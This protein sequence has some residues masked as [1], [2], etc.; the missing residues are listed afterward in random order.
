MRKAQNNPVE[1]LVRRSQYLR[2]ARA[3]KYIVSKGLILQ[4]EIKDPNE[5]GNKHRVGFTASKKVGNAVVRNR[6]RRR[7]KSVVNDVLTS[8][9][10]QPLDLVLIGRA[11]TLKR[12]YDELLSDFR[13]A[14]K[15]ARTRQEKVIGRA[16]D[17]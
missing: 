8:S 12:S 9:E 5:G 4:F 7:L 3:R 1:R 6:A 13:F 16:K 2:V 10:E 15:S 14:L 11:S 17:E